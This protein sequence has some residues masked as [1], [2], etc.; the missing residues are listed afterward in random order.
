MTGESESDFRQRH[1]FLS[2][3][4]SPDRLWGPP[5]SLSVGTEGSFPGSKAAMCEADHSLPSAAEAKMLGAMSPPPCASKAWCLIKYE[6]NVTVTSSNVTCRTNNG[7]SVHFPGH[8]GT[9]LLHSSDI[10]RL[11]SV[12]VYNRDCDSKSPCN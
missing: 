3:P 8:R 5:T 10:R 12:D 7:G 2:C 9:F 4:R 11:I 6:D 1:K